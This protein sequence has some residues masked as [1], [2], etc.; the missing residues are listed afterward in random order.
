MAAAAVGVTIAA[1]G[2]AG[3]QDGRHGYTIPHV[4]RYATGE[5]IVGLN[6]HLNAQGTLSYMSSLTMAW[7]IRY[8]HD[9]KPVPELAT[10]VPTLANHGIS[11]DGKTITYHLRTDA[12]WSDGVPFTSADVKFSVA[13]VQ[14]SDNNENTH[15]GFDDVTRVDT[16][17]PATAVFHLREPYSG[18]YV[19]F[20]SSAG[21]KPCILPQ[22]KFSSTKINT[23][24]YN[25]LPV[26]VGPFKYASWLRNDRV[27][28]VLDPLYFGGKP[29]LQRIIFKLIPDRNT[30]LTQLTTH[31]I[32]LWL[33]VSPAFADRVK[34]LPGIAFLQ[35]PSYLY[36]HIDFNISHPPLDDPVVRRALRFAIDRPTILAKVR[37]GNGVLQE[38]ILAPTHPFFDA[39]IARIPYDL[40]R[41]NALLD[42]AGWQ[43]GPDGIRQK[44][45]KRLEF[46]YATGVGLPDT[47]QQIELIRAGWKQI[48]V[49]FTVQRYPSS[50]F[51]APAQTGGIIFSGKYDITNF[52]WYDAVNGDARN[53]FGCDRV[54]PKGQN[55]GRYCNPAVDREMDRLL[56]SY[57]PKVQRSAALAIQ[58]QLVRDVATVVIEIRKD[59]FAFNADLQNF[60]PNQVTPFDAMLNVDI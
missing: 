22:H 16:P 48:G 5:D 59:T 30:T 49:D 40:G 4:L 24:A 8:D 52:A 28:M 34:D 37:H 57:D 3:S 1:P 33:P 32:D 25:D 6:P 9:N 38:G 23:A 19:D 36:D 12:K 18:Y 29:K 26:G 17:N 31:E 53:I 54:P 46:V 50:T 47:D 21:A 7:L 41:A 35:Q 43:R 60:R 55:V 27:E 10:S 20:F 51:F 44:N 42:G 2:P 15:E 56:A 11:K 39:S 45:G 58:E 14:D 13:V